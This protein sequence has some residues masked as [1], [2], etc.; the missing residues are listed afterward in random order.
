MKARAVVERLKAEQA[1]AAQRGRRERRDMLAVLPAGMIW[2]V[3]I[4]SPQREMRC[5]KALRAAGLAAFCPMETVTIGDRLRR[6]DVQ[7]ALFPRYVFLA[8]PQVG[9]LAAAR[10]LPVR[11]F[12]ADVSGLSGLVSRDPAA[13]DEERDLFGIDG[14]RGILSD[15]GGTWRIVPEQIVMQLAKAETVGLLDRSETVRR[16]RLRASLR[17][18]DSVT[19]LDG[20]FRGLIARVAASKGDNRLKVLMDVLGGAVAVEV[21]FDNV[22]K[23]A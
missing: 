8:E 15:A 7:R 1:D 20:P 17:E 5:E 10:P 11:V 23:T 21:G 18:G 2:R 16:S 4:V 6:R 12:R 19:I 13:R 3:G 9:M 22:A 14:L